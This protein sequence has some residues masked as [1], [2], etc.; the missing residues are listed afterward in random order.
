MNIYVSC[1]YL[2][3][4]NIYVS[5]EYL[6]IMNIYVSCEYLQVMNIYMSLRLFTCYEYLYKLWIFTG[7]CIQQDDC[8]CYDENGVAILPGFSYTPTDRACDTWWVNRTTVGRVSGSM[9]MP[10]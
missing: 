4:M 7:S 9:K 6:Q 2:Q 5:C 1:E 3:V 10:T 8:P